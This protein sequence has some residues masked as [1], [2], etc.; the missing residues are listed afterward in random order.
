MLAFLTVDP[1]TDIQRLV[2]QVGEIHGGIGSRHGGADRAGGR[3]RIGRVRIGPRRRR[4]RR[5]TG[6][7]ETVTVLGFYRPW[8]TESC[9]RH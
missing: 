4:A 2:V 3:I 8:S 7:Q 9:I 5:R 6:S 1:A